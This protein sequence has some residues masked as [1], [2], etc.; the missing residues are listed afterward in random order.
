MKIGQ[1][2]C[3]NQ[4]KTLAASMRFPKYQSG[5]P[6]FLIMHSIKLTTL[7]LPG[8][9]KQYIFSKNRSP[10]WENSIFFQKTI[11]RF[12]KT[13]FLLKEPFPDL[14]KQYFFSKSHFPVW[15]NSISFKRA[16]SRFGKAPNLLEI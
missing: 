2:S 15:E 8:L 3:N 12:G 1:K 16:V 7:P 9:G 4:E 10:V 14:G 5:Y 13:V 6:L 11:S